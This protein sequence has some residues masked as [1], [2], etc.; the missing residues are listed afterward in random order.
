MSEFAAIGVAVDNRGDEPARDDLMQAGMTNDERLSWQTNGYFVIRGFA[1]PSDMKPLAQRVVEIARSAD[2]GVD[3][4]PALI[5][6]EALLAEADTPEGRL[7]KIFRIHRQEPLFRRFCEEPRLLAKVCHLLGPDVDC[8]LSQFIFKHPGALGQPWHQDEWYF[9]MTPA[10]QVGV[11]LAVTEATRDNG[12][13]WVMPG[14]HNEEINENVI[15]DPREGANFAYVE[16]RDADTSGEEMLLM[17]PGDLL[18][19]HSHLRHRS[20]DNR[21]DRSRAAMVYHF[22]KHS[23]TGIDAGNQDWLPVA[24]AGGC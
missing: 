21:S 14:S 16:I 11:W 6:P 10:P 1:D 17:E 22:A 3:V 20:T 8:F 7:S 23:T 12:P 24:R 13:L 4:S 19:F 18:L 2:E 9:R 15:G 5:M